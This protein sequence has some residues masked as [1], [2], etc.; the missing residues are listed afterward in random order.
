MLAPPTNG[1]LNFVLP[2]FFLSRNGDSKSLLIVPCIT[3]GLQ[4]WLRRSE[5]SVSVMQ[6]HPV[7]WFVY[8]SAK[9]G[10]L[11]KNVWNNIPHIGKIGVH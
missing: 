5:Q 10:P 11:K 7:T 8:R 3:A 2:F 1:S 6:S 4:P 9:S